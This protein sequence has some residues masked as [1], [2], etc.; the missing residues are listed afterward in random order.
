LV[1]RS[2]GAGSVVGYYMDDGYI[3]TNEAWIEVGLNAS[4]VVGS[5]MV[6][7][8]DNQSFNMDSDTTHGNSTYT[9][10]FRNYTTSVRGIFTS[11]FTGNTVND[12]IESS[13][14]EP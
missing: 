5:H 6:L 1:V 7:F 14:Q 2:S 8:E 9:I 13:C 11:D 12:V 10:Y 4:H 3:A